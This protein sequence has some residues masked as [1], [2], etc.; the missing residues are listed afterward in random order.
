[1]LD[2]TICT[3]NYK[4]EPYLLANR[5]IVSKHS[6][7]HWVVVDN[8]RKGLR[9]DDMTVIDG[10]QRTEARPSVHH[11]AAMN[12][13]VGKFSADAGPPFNS[14]YVLLLDP[15]F[16]IVEPF[17]TMIDYMEK[18]S[19]VLFGAGY[20]AYQDWMYFGF[21]TTFCMLIDTM[22]L[23]IRELDFTPAYLPNTSHKK[24][25]AETGVRIYQLHKDKPHRVAK[26]VGADRYDYYE[27]VGGKP[28]GI[29]KHMR[30]QD[31]VPVGKGAKHL[32]RAAKKWGNHERYD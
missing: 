28:F 29:H 6:D 5:T 19:L 21:P 32:Y 2:L 23:D 15:D 8:E 7:V 12:M 1:M 17:Q 10:A 25:K 20:P 9:I 4:S 11:A 24:Y 30:V 22:R 13:A 16:Y 26:Y 18:R 3:V 14:R 31:G 27:L